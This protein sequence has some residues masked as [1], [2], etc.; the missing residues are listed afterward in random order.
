MA[1]QLF[2]DDNSLF[3]VDNAE[4]KY[5]KVEVVSEYHDSICS[6]DFCTGH[7]FKMQDG[8]F[9]MLYFAPVRALPKEKKLFIAESHDGLSF[10]PCRINDDKDGDKFPHEIF[11]LPRGSEVAYIYEDRTAAK[12]SEKYKLLMSVLDSDKLTV[13]DKVYASPD[14]IHW[15]CKE[16]VSLGN[17]AEPLVGVFYN[18][19]LGVHT[20]TQRPFWGIRRVGFKET[21]DWEHFTEYRECLN[22]DAA[23]ECLSEIYGM[24]AFEYGD[25]FIGIPHFYRGLHSELNAKYKEGIIDTQLAYSTDGRY[26]RR[27]LR[28]PFISGLD[29]DLYMSWVADMRVQDDGSILFYGSASHYEHGIGFNPSLT[30]HV[31]N[32]KIMIY[33]LRQDGFV[34]IT[35]KDSEKP[36]VIATRE[37]V[38]QGG[39]VHFNLKAKN[40]TVAVYS[41][42]VSELVTGNVLGHAKPIDGMGHK[43]CIPFSGDSTDWIPQ[44]RS[45]KCV[46]QLTN[47]TL[48]FEL[49]FYEGELYSTSGEYIDVF[50]TEAARYRKFGKLP[51][52]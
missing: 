31:K 14:L 39:E 10:K 5:G 48:I 36:T 11:T 52:N 1:K 25:Y 30:N 21:S 24:P 51:N 4:R 2:F 32:G 43:D 8:S 17:G 16:N 9:R 13:D 22:V 26:W 12:D 20:L 37:K 46:D 49:R 38:W 28:E 35:T 7:V 50:N 33:K 47:E 44:Y 34:A 23:D 3:S 42:S 45:G 19:R 41:S 15:E 29:R 6:I 27:S 18:S 40:A